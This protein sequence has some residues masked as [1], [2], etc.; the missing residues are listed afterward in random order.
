MI[1][2][3]KIKKAKQ[4]PK[5]KNKIQHDINQTTNNDKEVGHDDK[6]I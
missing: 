1:K 2:Q 3:F 4:N 5:D 6:E